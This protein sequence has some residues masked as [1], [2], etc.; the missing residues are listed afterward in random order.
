MPEGSIITD[1]QA[2]LE[3]RGGPDGR[4][5][6]RSSRPHRVTRLA[7][8][9]HR[10]AARLERWG[11]RPALV[12]IAAM[13]AI[14]GLAAVA[15]LAPLTFGV[16]A[17][18]FRRCALFAAEG[19]IDCDFVYSPLAALVARPLTWVSPTAAAVV[20]TLLG[21]AILVTGVR[22]E[23]RGH[24][25]FDRVLVA[26]AA[27]GFA[28]VVYELLLGQTTFLI[29]AAL[30]PAARRPDSFRTG[31]PFGIVLALAPKPLLIPVLVWM[32]VWRRRA[33]AASLLATVALTCLGL[34]LMGPEQYRQWVHVLTS[35]G[36][37]S[38]AGN[39]S[40]SLAGNFSLWPL[41]WTDLAIAAAVGAATLWAILRDPSRGFVASL[42]ASMVLAP[43]TGLYSAS[44][45]LLAVK[46]GLAFAPRATRLLALIAN[47]TLALLHALAVWSV[48]GLIACLS[49]TP[50]WSGRDREAMAPAQRAP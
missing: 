27:L 18:Y 29:A 45:L 35:A 21:F 2:D 22:H 40:L 10:L 12:A 50:R 13:N 3:G 23:T 9:R 5:E 41:D 24:A 44:I 31:I 37:A 17:E 33:L 39:L 43:Y 11:G 36:G 38:L 8:L 49:L 26:I 48:G 6:T 14:T 20:M 19:R 32:V 46:P 34:A 25:L 28:P 4:R 1:E 47:P 42:L 16:D 15:I 30:Y 7:L